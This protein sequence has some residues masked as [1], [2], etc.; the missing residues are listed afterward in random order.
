MSNESGQQQEEVSALEAMILETSVDPMA[1]LGAKMLE[2]ERASFV[3]KNPEKSGEESEK[4][5]GTNDLMET[6]EGEKNEGMPFVAEILNVVNEMSGT[7]MP[8]KAQKEG[9]GFILDDEMQQALDNIDEGNDTA[10]FGTSQLRCAIV[11]VQ[12]SM[13]VAMLKRFTKNCP[14]FFGISNGTPTGSDRRLR[15][16]D[17]VD[18]VNFAWKSGYEVLRHLDQDGTSPPWINAGNINI[19]ATAIKANIA[20]PTN[21]VPKIGI[22]LNVKRRG[23]RKT[24]AI[25]S[26][27][28]VAPGMKVAQSIPGWALGEKD[29][30]RTGQAVLVET[31]E[32]MRPNLW[33]VNS[34]YALPINCPFG[35]VNDRKAYHPFVAVGIDQSPILHKFPFRRGDLDATIAQGEQAIAA[36]VT[37]CL[38]K[39]EEDILRFTITAEPQV[40]YGAEADTAIITIRHRLDN[41]QEMVDMSKMW[42]EDQP[43]HARVAAKGAK[44]CATG[45]IMNVERQESETGLSIV[46]KLFLAYQE[47][48]NYDCEE[49]WDRI[50][51]G[52]LTEIEPLHSRKI[53]MQRAEKFSVN[54]FT[55][56]AKNT[57]TGLGTIMSILMARQGERTPPQNSWDELFVAKQPA[58]NDLI[59]G[60]R[61][62]ARLMLDSV[63]RVVF[64]QAPPGTGKTKVS[65][66]IIAAHLRTNP[67]AHV[68]FVAP[69]NVAVVKAVEEMAKT[70]ERMGWREDMLA[71]FSGSGKKK[72]MLE[73]NKIGPHLLA[74]ALRA[75]Q[76]FEELK[77]D[78]K[79]TVLRYI[80]ACETSPRTANEGKAAQIL[81]SKEKRR[82]IFCTL[83]LAEQ[84]GTMF[85]ETDMIIVDE[86]G[87][88][89]YVQL[90]SM[91]TNFPN[92]NK[93]LVAGDRWQLSVNLK[94]VPEAVQN[95][96]GLDTAILN[97]DAAAGV[98][99]TTLTVNF[100][101][102]PFITECIS[103]G[104]YAA[105]NEILTTGRTTKQMD[106][107]T[108]KTPISLPV[109]QCPI[110]LVH[111]IDRMQEDPT[112]F[113]ATNPMQTRTV[114]KC[115][116]F[117][118]PCFNGLIRV[119]CFYAGQAKEIGTEVSALNMPN[120]MVT[121]VDGCQ[122]HEAE[123]V[124]VVT[125]KAGLSSNDNSGA[126]WN[127][128][129]LT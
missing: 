118:R 30:F 25:Q 129:L 11:Q 104:V 14:W 48:K 39:L 29:W 98:D 7:E 83:S 85:D 81:L 107:L 117:L 115:L 45:F 8:E 64:M 32:L 96:Y 63:P 5:A 88:A 65:V 75:P 67:D 97:L 69:L 3:T 116:T 112:S 21:I 43:I 15:L 61:E 26:L 77:D 17:E 16:G 62:T 100:R 108:S 59:G 42:T 51:D 119:V 54:L 122:G 86:S 103:A 56:M 60:Q 37:A 94:D 128:E 109:P 120:V 47:A 114:M 78:Q 50:M 57:T 106:E 53:L 1:T 105:H 71:L 28:V 19:Q 125:T 92:L 79:R 111:Q 127:D 24:N 27:T 76:L 46:A 58:L 22:V 84:I 36:A 33:K 72:Y 12:S 93:L 99:R 4:S 23:M 44:P 102:H 89:S 110:I 70:M 49:A 66:D 124:F 87:Q 90:L 31:V 80:K 126:F 73:L 10:G 20:N 6:E 38:D 2:F 68:L 113:S 121:T 91:L 35:Q 40:E 82:I 34:I 9:F 41:K 18:I 74:A 55:E 13:A 101:S 95:G 52:E 123:F